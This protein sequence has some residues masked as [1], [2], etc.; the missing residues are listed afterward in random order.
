MAN[1][2][3]PYQGKKP[4]PITGYYY[5]YEDDKSIRH[6]GRALPDNQYNAAKLNGRNL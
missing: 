5:P 1:N 2:K 6:R 4:H 3:P